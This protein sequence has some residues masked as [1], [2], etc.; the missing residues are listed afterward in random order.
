MKLYLAVYTLD[1]YAY[2]G[3]TK[4][5]ETRYRL[6]WA[7]NEE[8]AREKMRIAYEF[9]ECGGDACHINSLEFEEAIQ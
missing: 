4:R 7:D 2:M 9:S 5:T 1:E 3:R 8:Q 6:V